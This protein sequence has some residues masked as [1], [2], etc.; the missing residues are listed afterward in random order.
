[1]KNKIWE[2]NVGVLRK[3]IPVFADLIEKQFPERWKYAAEEAKNGSTT[4]L[5]EKDGKYFPVHSRYDPEKEALQQAKSMKYRNPKMLLIFGL[6]LGYHIRAFIKELGKENIWIVIFERDSNALKFAIKHVDLTDLFERPNMRWMIGV[7]EEEALAICSDLIKQSGPAFQLFL[8]TVV[9]FEH[10]ALAKVHSEY[11]KIIL[12]NFRE[13]VQ[14][15]IVNYGTCPEDSM[16]GVK[17]IMK[18]LDV[19]LRNPGVMDLE[20][21]FKGVPGVVVSTGPSLDKNIRDLKGMTD[22]CVMICADSALQVLLNHGIV[23]HAF[24]TLERVIKTVD[25]YKD[26]PEEIMKQVWMAGTPVIRPEGYKAW[27]G[28]TFIVYR[29]FAHF[30]WI[31][32]EKGTYKIGPSCSNLAF[33]IL[34][35]MGCNPIILVGQDL[36]MESFQK[37]HA[38]GAIDGLNPVG[39][40]ESDLIKVKGNYQDWVHTHV[41]FDLFR[42]HFI[43]DVAHFQ[44]TVINSTAGGAFIDGT[45][46]MPLNEAL[47]KYCVRPVQTLRIFEKRLKYPRPEELQRVWKKFRQTMID[48]ATEVN[49]V[50][51][52]CS[53]QDK[54]IT[55]FDKELETEGYAEIED[56][57]KRYPDDRLNALHSVLTA[58]RNKTMVFGKYFELYLMHIVQMVIIRFEM[59]FNE[60]P[61]LCENE[62]R[63]K[64]QAIRLMKKWFPNIRD[65][66]K[67][68]LNLLLEAKTELEEKWGAV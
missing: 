57:L 15:Q 43:T 28:P 68:A 6:G 41:Y 54:I 29:E 56:F 38:E 48:T 30:K 5:I 62:K 66:C 61:S 51:E 36:A 55:A 24:A 20:G 13:G 11:N 22:R 12:R 4:M 34:E 47:A 50:I 63:C 35:A 59:D 18:N 42:K 23:P 7:P 17:N 60:I 40:K 37:T 9:V 25:V 19:I 46:L 33:K 14:S 26:T 3:R 2:K 31:G 49:E 67:L 8:K 16:L 65:L 44:G 64:L 58:A 52:F 10:A 21:A 32:V 53:E 45:V 27:K 1:M 39:F